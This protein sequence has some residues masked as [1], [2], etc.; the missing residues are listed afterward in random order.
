MYIYPQVNEGWASKG[1]SIFYIDYPDVNQEYIQSVFKD[2]YRYGIKF[3]FYITGKIGQYNFN[4]MM[5]AIIS[6]VVLFGTGATIII[7]IISNF[8]CSYTK[9]IMDESNES[10]HKINFTNCKRCQVVEEEDGDEDE[11]EN[12]NN[13]ENNNADFQESEI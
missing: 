1:S 2:R 5:D 11:D 13:M 9:K 4:N 6:G 12:N 8:C 7:L 3:K 10:S